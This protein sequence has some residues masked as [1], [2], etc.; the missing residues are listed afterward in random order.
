MSIGRRLSTE[1]KK[2][3]FSKE[4]KTVPARFYVPHTDIY[5]TDDA[6]TVD[7]ELT[8]QAL[9]FRRIVGPPEHD[10]RQEVYL[11]HNFCELGALD[12]EPRSADA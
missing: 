4:E 10:A 5:E 3:I 1:E 12:G 9:E 8:A 11:C 2:E 7:P 6:L